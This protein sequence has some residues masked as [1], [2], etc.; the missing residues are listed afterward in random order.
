MANIELKIVALGDFTSVNAQIKALQTQVESLQS[1]FAGVGLSNNVKSQLQGIQSEFSGALISSG[2]FTK[3]TVQLTSETEKFGKA[4]TSGRLGLGQYFQIITGKSGEAQKAVQALA[5]EQVKLN[6]S[7]V[8]T[9]I[10]NKGVYS[11]YTPTKIDEI[12]KATEIAAAKQNIYNLAIKNGSEQLINFGKNTQ[13][14][15]RQLTVGL[16]MPAILFGTQ[17]VAA[18]KS[19]NTEMTRLQRLYGEGLTPPSQTQLN[20]ISGQVLSLGKQIAEQMGIAQSETVKVAANFAAMGI[21]GQNLLDVTTQAQRLSKLGSIDATQATAAIVSLQNV[22]KVST[23]DLGNAVNFLSSMQKQTTMSLQDMTDAIPRVGPIMAQLGGNYKDT[24]VMLLAMKEAGVPAAQAANAL[25]S[26]FASIIAPTSAANKEFASFGINLANIKNAGTPTQMLMSL[27]TAL[28]PL[29]KMAQEQL[30]EK[31]FGKFQFSRIS[32]LLDNFGKAGSQT[33]NALKVAGAT[34]GQ[35]AALANQEMQQ[36]TESQTAKWQRTVETLKADLYPIGQEILKIGTAIGGFAV[37]VSDFFNKLPGPV[38]AVAAALAIL[39]V[40]AGPILML[41]GLFANLIGQGIRAGRAFVG[42]FDGTKKWKDLLTPA[43]VAAQATTDAFE[44]G[45]F[46]DITAVDTLNMSLQKLIANL[47]AINASMNIRTGSSII[48]AI[49]GNAAVELPALAEDVARIAPMGMSTGGYIPGNPSNGDSQPA[50]LTG[51]EAVI[52]VGPAKTYAPFINAMI[53]GTLPMHAGGRRAIGR[54]ANDVLR[55]KYSIPSRFSGMGGFGGTAGRSLNRSTMYPG[56]SEEQAAIRESVMSEGGTEAEAMH[57]SRPVIEHTV[58]NIPSKTTTLGIPYNRKSTDLNDTMAG[59]EAANLYGSA[60]TDKN[61]EMSPIMSKYMDAVKKGQVSFEG[62]ANSQEDLIKELEKMRP[63]VS[64]DTEQHKKIMQSIA[65]YDKEVGLS[66]EDQKKIRS[67]TQAQLAARK[68]E[69]Y[70]GGST[71]APGGLMR[72]SDKY[73]AQRQKIMSSSERGWKQHEFHIDASAM[74]KDPSLM[75]SENAS[76]LMA[77]SAGLINFASGPMTTALNEA[78]A[79]GRKSVKEQEGIASPSKMWEEEVGKPLAEGIGEGFQLELPGITESMKKSITEMKGQVLIPIKSV[80]SQMHQD[81]L[82]AAAEAAKAAPAF[83]KSGEELGKAEAQGVQ[84]ELNLHMNDMKPKTGIQDQIESMFPSMNSSN[85]ISGENSAFNKKTLQERFSGAFGAESKI[86]GMA[87]NMLGSESMI[88]KVMGKW[89]NMG[90]MGKMGVGAGLGV[91]S[92]MAAPMINKALG[93]TAGGLANDALSG[94][95]M[96]ASF[97]PWGAAAGAA[98]GLVTGGIKDLMAAEKLHKQEADADFKASADAVQFFGAQLDT[99]THKMIAFHLQNGAINNSL[100]DTQKK[101]QDAASGIKYTNDQLDSFKKMVQGLPK[102]NPLSLVIQQIQSTSDQGQARKLAEDF[103]TMQ[104]SISGI[105]QAQATQLTQ[106]MLTMG[107]KYAGGAGVSA[108]D[109]I[110]AIKK[111]LESMAGD[112]KKFTD[113]IGQ[114]Q[115]IAVSS[116]SWDQYNKLI[117]A[118]GTS[119]QG[120]DGYVQ[121]LINHLKGIGDQQG[122]SQVAALQ[123]AGYG[124]V[125]NINEIAD[126]QTA[127]AAGLKLN[128]D[129]LTPDKAKEIHQAAQYAIALNQQA[130]NAQNQVANATNNA[131]AATQVNVTALQEQKKKLDETLK[132]LQLLQKQTSQQTT[133]GTTMEDLKNQMLMAQSQ[134]DN[135]KAQLLSQQI[136]GTTRDYN[137]QNQVDAAQKAVDDKQTEIDNAN[138]T[139]IVTNTANTA[140]NVASGTTAVTTAVGNAASAIAGAVGKG[141]TPPTPP[142]VSLPPG[143]SNGGAGNGGVSGAAVTVPHYADI[144]ATFGKGLEAVNANVAQMQKGGSSIPTFQKFAGNSQW[145]D[146]NGILTRG[147]VRYIVDYGNNGKGFEKGDQ[148]TYGDQVYTVTTGKSALGTADAVLQASGDAFIGSGRQNYPKDKPYNMT[149]DS[150]IEAEIDYA[151]NMRYT[152]GNDGDKK[153]AWDYIMSMSEQPSLLSQFMSYLKVT[154][155]QNLDGAYIRCLGAK[156][157]CITMAKNPYSQ[158]IKQLEDIYQVQERVHLIQFQLI[159]QMENM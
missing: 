117:T 32:A 141:N 53:D 94:A 157:T 121:A 33:Q 63:N 60:L 12:S 113:F 44:A 136:M 17:A 18:F 131:A 15:G 102:D 35:L 28:A 152:P 159:F 122:A 156:N 86:G 1:S 13:W 57:L 106:M 129:V 48:S 37:K 125:G 84:Q 75:T 116:T 109:Q 26:A 154:D 3:Q 30:I 77:N 79:S 144:Q 115:D 69:F 64:A 39:T 97:G 83:K 59:L 103:A 98:I 38:K 80:G 119:A 40:L 74:T 150:L 34:N 6:N 56:M 51:G 45:M 29:N 95:A 105:S 7:I 151:K 43:G 31:L 137:L 78:V 124:Q 62:L 145:E 101:A 108:S 22:Y 100:S 111:T 23:Q 96:G 130:A 88:G 19:V 90:M 128:L 47:E 112:T 46:K 114:I 91:V 67:A 14:A 71:P 65:A 61:G 49:E 10:T 93:P 70:E 16:A 104:M 133:Y 140:S 142:G 20:Q 41:T 110:A 27:Q 52:P 50:L 138:Q 148:F 9:D 158:C 55:E 11:V 4:L 73:E 58:P 155:P 24:A 72:G 5:V 99:A 82:E 89:S 21:Q 92:Q 81:M 132:S 120:A 146:S 36:A 25:K 2:A 147:A 126:I 54:N 68:S 85:V 143:A 139:S 153:A 149:K 118:I 76:R 135:L 127:E 123:R 8:Q 107:G 66:T 42:L 87:E 134:G